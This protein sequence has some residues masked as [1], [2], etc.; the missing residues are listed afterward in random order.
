MGTTKPRKTVNVDEVTAAAL[1]ELARRDGR[2]FSNY[3]AR[4]LRDH[5]ETM[6]PVAI[7]EDPPG[8][9]LPGE[10]GNAA[11]RK[12]PPPP[13]QPYPERKRPRARGPSGGEIPKG[14]LGK[15]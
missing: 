7:G 6:R 2:S 12:V 9:D 8:E 14:P 5:V 4:I 11:L 13:T 10:A 15:A 3:A 1:V